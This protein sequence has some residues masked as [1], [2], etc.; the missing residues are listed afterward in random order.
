MTYE[1]IYE[2][3][4][5]YDLIY[6][7]TLLTYCR[8]PP[9]HEETHELVPVLHTA[10]PCKDLSHTTSESIR[11]ATSTPLRL[12]TSTSPRSS[13]S[14]SP[15]SATSTSTWPS[16][17]LALN[18]TR[19]IE[20]SNSKRQHQSSRQPSALRLDESSRYMKMYDVMVPFD[21]II[22]IQHCSFCANHMSLRHH[23]E[24]YEEAAVVMLKQL[25]VFVI[26]SQVPCRLA[27][28]QVSIDSQPLIHRGVSDVGSFE[29]QV[30]F[31]QPNGTLTTE[32]LHS[33]LASRS[34]GSIEGIKHRLEAFISLN[35]AQYMRHTA[36][37]SALI[38]PLREWMPMCGSP[39]TCRWSCR[40]PPPITRR[41]VLQRLL[42]FSQKYSDSCCRLGHAREAL[43]SLPIRRNKATNQ[44]V[45][46]EVSTELLERT[47]TPRNELTSSDVNADSYMIDRTV[48]ICRLNNSSDL[49]LRFLCDFSNFAVIHRYPRWH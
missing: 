13:S 2:L 31:M 11:N 43:A 20:R 12:M 41:V 5:C 34:W 4:F 40:L 29:V 14:T 44:E 27:L 47:A 32:L 8:R 35:I 10:T 28:A 49:A 18:T 36:G 17:S 15:R 42:T 48:V 24:K 26:A 25:G 19:W 3:K 38:E 6:H 22:S 16:E 21:L 45:R 39:M 30:A 23:P 37:S 7:Y 1:A 33:K 9:R 46:C